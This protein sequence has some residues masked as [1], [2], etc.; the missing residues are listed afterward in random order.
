[1]INMCFVETKL[2]GIMTSALMHDIVVPLGFVVET[3]VHL[4]RCLT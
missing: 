2:S 1:M 3:C 4:F